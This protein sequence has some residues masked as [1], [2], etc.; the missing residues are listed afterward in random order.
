MDG[1]F[2]G[3]PVGEVVLEFEEVGVDRLD[4]GCDP[5]ESVPRCVRT[6]V[7]HCRRVPGRAWR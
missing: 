5:S 7:S 1:F 4:H 2:D 6:K 3:L